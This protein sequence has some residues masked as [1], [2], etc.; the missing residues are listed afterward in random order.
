MPAPLPQRATKGNALPDRHT[1][2]R[3]HRH[4]LDDRSRDSHLVAAGLAEPDA[5]RRCRLDPATHPAA[6]GPA[7]EM[8]LAIEPGCATWP[9][10]PSLPPQ[11]A[12]PRCCGSVPT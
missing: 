10:T 6:D 4:V 5:L 9:G 8:N 2:M 3:A 1:A 12:P 7:I 11:G